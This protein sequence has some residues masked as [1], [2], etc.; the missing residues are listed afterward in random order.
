M[1]TNNLLKYSIIAASFLLSGTT[2]GQIGIN[3]SNPDPS[4]VL[5]INDTKRG[6]IFPRIDTSGN[7]TS[8]VFGVMFYNTTD[9][10]VSF[11]DG[12]EWKQFV[13]ATSTGNKY[14]IKKD[15]NVKGNFAAGSISSSGNIDVAGNI[16]TTGAVKAG[17]ISTSGDITASGTIE[18]GNLISTGDITAS[19]TIKAGN[20]TSTGDITAS[21]NISTATGTVTANSFFT[22]GEYKYSN[23]TSRFMIFPGTSLYGSGLIYN[24]DNGYANLNSTTSQGYI[25]LDIPIGATVTAVDVTVSDNSAQDI[26]V[27]LFKKDISNNNIASVIANV[28]TSGTP[29]LITLNLLTTSFTVYKTLNDA[30]YL[31][32]FYYNPTANSSLL[33]YGTRVTYSGGQTD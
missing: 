9:S 16:T 2:Y 12:N 22:D 10:V 5:H 3:I 27:R 21:G 7:I 31:G 11:F 25:V 4:A 14:V 20:L 1:K 18:A 23:K 28:H 13:P 6:V 32:V 15:V 24:Y 19:D 33:F 30:Y 8:P 26:G 29:G 17:E